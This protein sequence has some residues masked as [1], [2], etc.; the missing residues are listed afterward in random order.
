MFEIFVHPSN[1]FLTFL[2]V[3]LAFYWLVVL[4]GAIDVDMI[5]FDFEVDVDV[6]VDADID[7]DTE[8]E[9]SNIFGLNKILHFF[10]LGRVPFMVFLTFLVMPWWF[11]TVIINHLFGITSF[12]PGFLISLPVLIGA[13]FVA[14]LLTTP[15]VKIF[16]ALEKESAERDVLGTIG[17]VRI[18]ASPTKTG[19]AEFMLGN[20]FLELK[21]RTKEGEVKTRDKVMIV[22]DSNKDE[23]YLVE[24]HNEI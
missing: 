21:I 6:D 7:V 9:S 19:L 4:F 12:V 17:E 16:D 1:I 13:L 20:A 18:G 3:L 10:N 22:N 8:V 24:I 23:Y 2:M 15:F 5:D 14:K 11:G